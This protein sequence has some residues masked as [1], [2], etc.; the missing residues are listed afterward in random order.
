MD[1][2]G[3]F[4]T[5]EMRNGKNAK[6]AGQPKRGFHKKMASLDAFHGSCGSVLYCGLFERRDIRHRSR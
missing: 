6:I 3:V 4:Q 2:T 1:V 5:E